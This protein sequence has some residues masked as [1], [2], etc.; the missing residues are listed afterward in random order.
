MAKVASE[1]SDLLILTSDNPRNENPEE[2]IDDMLPGIPQGRTQKMI[3]ISE[4]R[5]A[6]IA[7]LSTAQAGDIVLIAGKGH[8]KYQEIKGQKFPFDDK[9]IVRDYLEQ[10]N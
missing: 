6:I 3:R 8:E 1:R 9:E 10:K 2:I 5:S 7:G 4:R